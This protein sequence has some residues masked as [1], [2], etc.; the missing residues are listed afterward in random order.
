MESV[1][2]NI[3]S[4]LSPVVWYIQCTVGTVRDL[5]QAE[6]MLTIGLDVPQALAHKASRRDLLN[7]NIQTHCRHGP[8]PSVGVIGIS[9]DSSPTSMYLS[10]ESPLLL[11]L[12][13]LPGTEAPVIH[14]DIPQALCS[15]NA[16]GVN[17]L[18][19]HTLW[20]LT[21]IPTLPLC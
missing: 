12:D 5:T 16:N 10:T 9:P 6:A 4:Y 19:L 15:Q 14:S 11:K 1:L 21:Q 13:P 20:E 3:A 7:S 18:N 8:G 2:C 17:L